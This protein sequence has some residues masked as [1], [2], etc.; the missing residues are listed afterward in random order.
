M[1]KMGHILIQREVH[2]LTTKPRHASAEISV[3]QPWSHSPAQ[4]PDNKE[5]VTLET[6]RWE[7]GLMLTLNKGCLAVFLSKLAW[8]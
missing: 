4:R 6:H 5:A 1:R 8:R 7:M 3:L 2:A